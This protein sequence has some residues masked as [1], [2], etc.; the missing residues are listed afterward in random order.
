METVDSLP[1]VAAMEGQAV[2][3]ARANWHGPSDALV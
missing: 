2:V 1:M 3:S